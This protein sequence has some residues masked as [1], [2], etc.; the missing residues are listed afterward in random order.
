MEQYYRPPP[1]GVRLPPTLIGG[2]GSR[3]G[4]GYGT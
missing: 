2:L 4:A 3:P 1:H